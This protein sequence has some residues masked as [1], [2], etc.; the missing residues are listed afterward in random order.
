[1]SVIP[2][3]RT[4]VRE[5]IRREEEFWIRV[6]VD[7]GSRPRYTLRSWTTIARY[8]TDIII[9]NMSVRSYVLGM[10]FG[11]M[12]TMTLPW[13]NDLVSR[14]WHAW[15]I[16]NNGVKMH[17][18]YQWK[19]TGQTQIL[20]RVHFAWYLIGIKLLC[21]SLSGSYTLVQCSSHNLVVNTLYYQSNRRLILIYTLLFLDP[22]NYIC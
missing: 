16:D 11:Y 2:I 17:P 13:R 8:V 18:I 5:K 10:Y 7:F 19:F 15:F 3:Q 1:M 6:Y 21:A 12:C 22:K 4:R 14:S 9:S 20:C